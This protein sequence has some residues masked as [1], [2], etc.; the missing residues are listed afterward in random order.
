MNTKPTDTNKPYYIEIENHTDDRGNLFALEESTGIPFPIKRVF[1]VEAVPQ[2]K[3]RGGHA[4]VNANQVIVCLKGKCS[5]ATKDKTGSESS[6]LINGEKRAL[7]VPADTWKELT[8]FEEGTILAVLTDKEYA[9]DI[10]ISDYNT[11][12]SG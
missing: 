6:F 1:F 4:N 3:S 7:F 11:F 8:G 12:I 9:G 10:K 5:I 2:G